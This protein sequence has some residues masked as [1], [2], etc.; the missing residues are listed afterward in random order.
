MKIAKLIIASFVLIGCQRIAAPSMDR[1]NDTPLIVDEAMQKRDW[2]PSAAYYPNG[3][4]VAG[5]NG[6]VIETHRRV[7]DD[8]RRVT[9]PGMSVGN[10]GMLPVTFPLKA[11]RGP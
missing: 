9:D 1:V 10:I 4:T 5:F 6:Q 11:F 3:A 2:Q 7:P 8:Y